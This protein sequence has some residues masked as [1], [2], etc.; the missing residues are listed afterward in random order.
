MGRG[1]EGQPARAI[2]LVG[3]DVGTPVIEV[4]G[5]P[6][7]VRSSARRRAATAGAT[8]GR[9]RPRRRHRRILRTRS[10]RARVR[11]SSPR[12]KRTCAFI[13]VA[14]TRHTTCSRTSSRSSARRARGDQ[15]RP[16]AYDA[17]TTIPCTSFGRRR[18]SPPTGVARDRLGGSGNGEQ[19]AANKVR[20]IRAALC[21]NDNSPALARQHNNAQIISIGA[22]M[23]PSSRRDRWSE[24]SSKPRSAP[25]RGTLADRT[26][27]G[28]PGGRGP[29][30]PFPTERFA[31][32]DDG[33]HAHGAI[34][35]VMGG[36][37]SP[38]G[39]GNGSP[40]GPERARPAPAPHRYHQHHRGGL[41]DLAQRPSPGRLRPHAA[42]R[43]LF[44]P[45]GA[46]LISFVYVS[47]AWVTAGLIVVPESRSR[48]LM[49]YPILATM[50]VMYLLSA[51][52]YP[53]VSSASSVN[54]CSWTCRAAARPGHDPTS[55]RGLVGGARDRRGPQ[56]V[57]LGRLPPVVLQ[58]RG[59]PRSSCRR[60]R[61]GAR[62]GTRALM[63]SRAPSA[64]IAGPGPRTALPRAANGY[65]IRELARGIRH[66]RPCRSGSG[67]GRFEIGS[68]GH[69]PAIH[70]DAEHGV[71]EPVLTRSGPCAQRDGRDELPADAAS[72]GIGDACC[73]I[74]TGHRAT[75]PTRRRHRLDA[76]GDRAG[77]V[78]GL[79]ASPP[80]LCRA[81]RAAPDDYAV[82]LIWQG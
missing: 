43:R 32:R 9:M 76:R 82:L 74:R 45:P 80:K 34:S 58:G 41:H 66:G 37:A 6:S 36:A 18:Q 57:L 2:D 26:A 1:A 42:A 38:A 39:G 51:A 77:R 67:D 22:R 60:Q 54:G 14:T 12:R 35:T 21:Y 10:G 4:E 64:R 11:R 69:P 46:L 63:L 62:A 8:V 56:G 78:T 19:I 53:L 68:A 28:I 25:S 81:A 15:P 61:Q 59:K 65:L 20:G 48:G 72:A 73:S 24:P 33:A 29:A 55:A 23:V 47:P 52:Q 49:G 31:L 7:S 13:S 17:G 30:P 50:V 27:R 70:F 79:P 71:W 40:A 75:Q 3:D 16:F 44:L 5:S